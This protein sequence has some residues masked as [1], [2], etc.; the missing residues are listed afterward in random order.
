MNIDANLIIPVAPQN[1]LGSQYTIYQ[2]DMNEINLGSYLLTKHRLPELLYR[3]HTHAW[4]LVK[5][6]FR[7]P[8]QPRKYVNLEFQLIL[9]IIDMNKSH[10]EA[11]II[12]SLGDFKK[13]EDN[14]FDWFDKNIDGCNLYVDMFYI[15]S[16]EKSAV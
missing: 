16:Y 3:V 15:L 6:L 1:F 10:L 7:Y 2:V 13:W 14:L 4:N 8:R 5:T 9:K 11:P 12:I